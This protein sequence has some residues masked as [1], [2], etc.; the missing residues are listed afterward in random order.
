MSLK[1]FLDKNHSTINT[2]SHVLT[3][4]QNSKIQK[5]QRQ[6]AQLEVLNNSL[7]NEQNELRENE[8]EKL[9]KLLDQNEKEKREKERREKLKTEVLELGPTTK[10]I[11]KKIKEDKESFDDLTLSFLLRHAELNVQKMHDHKNL[12]SDINYFDYI[13]NLSDRVDEFSI[14]EKDI[15]ENYSKDLANLLVQFQSVVLGAEL[16]N[17][18]K[19]DVLTEQSDNT[20]KYLKKLKNNIANELNDEESLSKLVSHLEFYMTINKKI[21]EL[22]D[23]HDLKK[24]PLPINMKE[25]QYLYQ[26]LIEI[27]NAT[28]S[29][30][31]EVDKKV[32]DLLSVFNNTESIIKRVE[33]IL[34]KNPDEVTNDDLNFLV[35]NSQEE[36]LIIAKEKISN[37]LTDLE[38]VIQ[39]DKKLISKMSEDIRRYQTDAFN[40]LI[41]QENVQEM[42]KE[43]S[44]KM[45]KSEAEDV[46]QMV[47]W[48]VISLAVVIFTKV[49][50]LL[51][52]T[53]GIVLLYVLFVMNISQNDVTNLF[54]IKALSSIKEVETRILEIKK[55]I[56]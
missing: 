50:E 1:E 4:F 32:D 24:Y 45:K 53:F 51:F 35:Q 15:I 40:T 26:L 11:L 8:L 31:E 12:I 47:I 23:V 14:S 49:P 13:H 3:Y 27:D 36:V 10:K 44:A 30:A 16:F 21:K 34:T 39:D 20:K 33:D 56:V 46:V 9:E 17:K 38:E 41:V 54:S 5:N 18:S 28:D 48:V 52:V 25:G 22:G 29:F 2:T 43:F 55:N 37:F 6:L 19:I 42:L 7:L